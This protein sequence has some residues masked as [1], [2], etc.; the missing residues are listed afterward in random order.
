MVIRVGFASVRG[1]DLLQPLPL[2]EMTQ[3][4]GLQLSRLL[5]NVRWQMGLAED[6]NTPTPCLRCFFPM[7]L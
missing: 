6:L 3:P 4:P 1:K 5:F 7:L 2:L